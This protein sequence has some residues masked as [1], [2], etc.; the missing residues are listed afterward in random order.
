M[1]RTVPIAGDVTHAQCQA[2]MRGIEA[3]VGEITDLV[4]TTSDPEEGEEPANETLVTANRFKR[5]TV[6]SLHLVAEGEDPPEGTELKVAGTAWIAD[7]K[8]VVKVYR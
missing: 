2:M 5:V 1:F 3:R 6:N 8:T 4:A 7:K